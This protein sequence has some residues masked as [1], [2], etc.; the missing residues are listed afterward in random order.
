MAAEVKEFK[1]L[2][3]FIAQLGSGVASALEDG[4]LSL[5]DVFKILPAL[6]LSKAAIEGIELIP[7]ELWEA[8]EVDVAAL[9]EY[10]AS[11]FDIPN[12]QL[13]ATV[14]RAWSAAVSFLLLVRGFIGK[15]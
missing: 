13:E 8:D 6:K 5:T 12:D 3:K 7:A 10:F 1:E 15:K 9:R 14:E 11:E 2:L 4:K